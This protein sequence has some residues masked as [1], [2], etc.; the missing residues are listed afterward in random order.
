MVSMLR[1]PRVVPASSASSPLARASSASRASATAA[2][3]SATARRSSSGPPPRSSRC[4]AA[5]ASLRTS[6]SLAS[7]LHVR[8]RHAP[9][10]REQEKMR[11]TDGGRSR[12]GPE[13]WISRQSIVESMGHGGSVLWV[14]AERRVWHCV[15]HTP[16]KNSVLRNRE[17][18]CLSAVSGQQEMNTNAP[19]HT[20]SSSVRL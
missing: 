6:S 16:L 14:R 11:R 13:K 19:R 9:R 3:S 17:R 20:H 15:A 12:K 18:S 10:H 4:C 8:T 7:R 2:S 1:I 5:V